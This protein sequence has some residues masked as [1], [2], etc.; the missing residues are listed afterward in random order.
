MIDLLFWLFLSTIFYTYAGYPVL[1]YFITKVNAKTHKKIPQRGEPDSP[2]L[3][4]IAAYNEEDCIREKLK[5]TLALSYPDHLLKV[6]VVA[7]GSTDKTM[8]IARSF[9]GVE[10]LYEP[11]RKGKTAAINRAMRY[12]KTPFVIFTDANTMLNENAVKMI[13]QHYEDG[14]VGGVSGE[15]KVTG[16]DSGTAVQSEGLYWKYESFIKKL[17]SD[18]YTAVGAAGELFSIR[19]ELFK[20]ME[21]DTLLDDFIISLKICLEGYRVVYEPEAYAMEKPS[22]NMTEE[23]KRKIRIGAGAFQAIERLPQ[24]LNFFK[25]PAL[26]FQYFSH[27]FLRWAVCP[28][29]LLPLFI[30]NSWLAITPGTLIY[31]IFLWGQ[32]LFYSLVITG[33]TLNKMHIKIR[34]LN[35][36]YYF[37]FMNYCIIRGFIRYMS[38][39]QAASW[40]KAKRSDR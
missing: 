2:V 1:L 18:F 10:V 12:V 34:L 21:E 20:P 16:D 8:E 11:A 3:V 30:I 39:S 24:L 4:L 31:I 26:A 28:F 15:K 36:P 5:N 9:A 17:D 23:A 14:T 32:I 22:A 37:I 7:D 35:T 13:V 6:I 25:Y 38:G 27:R 33:W 19:T 29:L 40:E